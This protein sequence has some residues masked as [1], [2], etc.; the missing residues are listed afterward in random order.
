MV[1]L[2]THGTQPRTGAIKQGHAH[3]AASPSLTPRPPLRLAAAQSGRHLLS[4]SLL[5]PHANAKKKSPPLLH[6]PRSFAHIETPLTAA[7]PLV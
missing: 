4:L 1:S 2:Q 7:R 3:A 6:C 5:P